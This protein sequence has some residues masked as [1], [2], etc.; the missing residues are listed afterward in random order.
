MATRETWLQERLNGIGAS[1]AA[2]ILGLSP[3]MTNEKL[4]EIKTGRATQD[5]ISDKPFVKFGIEAEKHIRALFALDNPQLKVSYKEFQIFRN[6]DYP[7][8]FATLDG[9]L[10]ENGRMGVWECKTT[11][12]VRAGQWDEW[13]CRVP[14]NYYCQC[15]WQ[16]LATGYDFAILTAR[17]KYTDRNGDK[18][19]TTKDY[20]F[21]RANVQE[22]IDWIAEKGKEF[23]GYVQNDIKPNLILPSI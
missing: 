1:D 9:W 22:D 21:E 10:E 16:L 17:I 20:R 13:R 18:A 19:T 12:I 11:E 5:D 23:W 14:Q 6:S 7:F 2:A 3:Y 15:L 4:W 8:I